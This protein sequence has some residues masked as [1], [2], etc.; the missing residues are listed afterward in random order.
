MMETH[1]PL[2]P[3]TGQDVRHTPKNCDDGNACTIDSCDQVKGCVH[4]QKN[5]DDRNA[6]TIDICDGK[7]HCIHILKN[8]DDGNP[9]TVDACDTYWG[10]IHT[11]VVCGTGK[12]CING[13]CLPVF[14]PSA[15]APS[16]YSIPAGSAIA[17]PWGVGRSRLSTPCRW[18]T[19][20]HIPPDLL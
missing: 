18:R 2:I 3:S 9:C 19:G 15:I 13:A 14:S 1:A 12:T 4:I 17:L 6:C 5:C 11:P 10:C 7:G 20:L 16:S 8:C